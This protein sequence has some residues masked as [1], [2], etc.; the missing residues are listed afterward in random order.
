MEFPRYFRIICW[1][2]PMSH[3]LEQSHLGCNV[4]TWGCSYGTAF[5]AVSSLIE[6]ALHCDRA[7]WHPAICVGV[8]FA[9]ERQGS[10]TAGEDLLDSAGCYG[11][12]GGMLIFKISHAYHWHQMSLDTPG[13]NTRSSM[14]TLTWSVGTPMTR[15]RGPAI[16]TAHQP[17][18]RLHW[19]R[20]SN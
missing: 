19:R 18:R 4:C 1:S 13:C 14:M 20:G 2:Q 3:V 16:L 9:P 7:W 5:R 10:C 12:Q 11:T 15:F 17:M 8:R 6:Q